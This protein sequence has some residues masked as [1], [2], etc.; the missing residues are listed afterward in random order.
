[1][2]AAAVI[3]LGSTPSN[4]LPQRAVGVQQLGESIR[5]RFVAAVR[6]CGIAP[7]FVP[8]VVV[9][10]SSTIDVH[11]SSDDRS[12]HL[13]DWA[14]LDANSRGAI[15]AWAAQGTLGLGP[16][17]MYREMFDSFIVPHE[18][19]H[20]LQGFSGRWRVLTH[21][22]AELEANRIA[23]AFWSLQRGAEGDVAARIR[24]ISRFTDGLPNPVPAGEDAEAFF[25][26]NYAAFERGE[27]G[28]LNPMNY[29]WFQAR[30]MTTAHRERHANG[31][32]RLV[33]INAPQRN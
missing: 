7:P 1:M 33:A 4:A 3:S 32:C 23:V 19:G 17:A 16:E 27:E 2:F 20:Y 5:D 12:I 24:N 8:R 15:T 6:H 14:N 29:S 26:R 13:T 9:D 10:T 31:F 22:Q 18:L 11:Y 30:M 25:N 28:P 21:W